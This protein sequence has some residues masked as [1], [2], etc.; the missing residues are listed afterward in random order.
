M[1]DIDTQRDGKSMVIKTTTRLGARRMQSC[2][3]TGFQNLRVEKGDPPLLEI[4][5]ASRTKVPGKPSL[6][7]GLEILKAWFRMPA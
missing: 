2:G 7:R 5:C 6:E 3:H 1:Q 4:A